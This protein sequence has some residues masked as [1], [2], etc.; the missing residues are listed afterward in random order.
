MPQENGILS[1]QEI[2]RTSFDAFSRRFLYNSKYK[3]DASNKG[4][5]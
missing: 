4:G 1:K 3:T 5:S 2:F